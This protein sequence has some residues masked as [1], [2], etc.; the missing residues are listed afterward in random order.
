MQ[1]RKTITVPKPLEVVFAYLCDFTT[2]TEWDPG[3]V[4]TVRESGD[5]G[6]G[7]VYLNTSRLLG[8]DTQLRYVLLD[9]LPLQRLQLRGENATLVAND[10][11][12]FTPAR[13]GTEVTYTADFIFKGVTRILAPL[14]RPALRRLGD[15]AE[16]GMRSALN[17]LTEP[18]N[19]GPAGPQQPG[20]N[21]TGATP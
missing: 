2:T 5:G 1:I 11:M 20:R 10:T 19:L 21:M 3:T 17:A 8:R 7:T 13:G 9:L 6:V 15:N 4:Q 18:P 16:A 14:L 12:T